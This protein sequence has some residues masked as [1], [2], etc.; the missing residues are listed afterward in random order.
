MI[1]DNPS[2]YSVSEILDW[3]RT[4]RDPSDHPKAQAPTKGG[5]RDTYEGME[6]WV[7]DVVYLLGYVKAKD[8]KDG[9]DRYQNFLNSYQKYDERGCN[10]L[11]GR[12]YHTEAERKEDIEDLVP[13]TTV[14][15]TTTT[16]PVP[17]TTTT[18]PVGPESTTTLP[19]PSTTTTTLPP[20]TTTIPPP[21]TTVPDDPEA[22]DRGRHVRTVDRPTPD[23]RGWTWPPP[24]RGRETVPH[25]PRAPFWPRAMDL[26]PVMAGR[27]VPSREER[28]KAYEESGAGERLD[29][30]TMNWQ[31]D[32]WGGGPAFIAEQI[33]GDPVQIGGWT[34]W[35]EEGPIP[36]VLDALKGGVE[37]S[38]QA[39]EDFWD[40]TVRHQWP[41][42][43]LRPLDDFMNDFLDV[44]SVVRLGS[45]GGP[46]GTLVEIK[47][48]TG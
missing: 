39:L 32:N 15:T 47:R 37:Q 5:Y 4:S 38:M 40:V 18:T 7:E 30:L 23:R 9:D 36:G 12:I 27:P 21:T 17:A 13:T 2:A 44:P 25:S 26:P 19:P 14:P 22:D 31:E 33:P 43:G 46:P 11:I 42:T 34:G 3:I 16:V 1:V 10:A 24:P 48:T 45:P 8:N 6:Q 29:A 41:D 20:P 35:P 28:R